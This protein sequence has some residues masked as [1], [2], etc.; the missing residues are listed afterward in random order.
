M[1]GTCTLTQ[2]CP[3]QQ[4]QIR[5]SDYFISYVRQFLRDRHSYLRRYGAD[6]V[7]DDTFQL[8]AIF[9]QIGL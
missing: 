9:F 3:C 5:I 6:F 2:G 4:L 8:D 7:F 1:K